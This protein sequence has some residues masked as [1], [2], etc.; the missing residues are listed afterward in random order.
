MERRIDN[1]AD[2]FLYG[3]GLF[4]T[5]KVENREPLNL[6]KHFKRLSYSAEKL[7][8]NIELTFVEF[9]SL[10]LDEIKLYKEKNYILRISFIKDKDST[11][12][13]FNKRE[14]LYDINSYNNGFKLKISLLKKDKNSILVYHKTLNYMENILA[15]SKAKADG[16]GEV[17]FFNQEGYLCEGAISNI[18]LIKNNIIYTPSLQNG[19]LN[20]IMRDEVINKLEKNNI[21]I[22]EGNIDKKFLLTCE[23]VFITNSIFGIMKVTQIEDKKYATGFVEKLKKLLLL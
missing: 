17:L 1:I 15:L 23:E 21:K 8:I 9:K 16:Y 22:I 4:E 14:N 2:G 7:N 11:Q 10:F 19:L 18:F 3:Y 20:G 12:Y 6:E 5:V 13:F